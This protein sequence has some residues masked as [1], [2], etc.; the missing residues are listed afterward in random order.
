MPEGPPGCRVEMDNKERA[1][2]RILQ[3]PRGPA[4]IWHPKSSA[5][6]RCVSWGGSCPPGLLLSPGPSRVLEI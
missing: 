1:C 4:C 2:P 5:A 6:P 3:D